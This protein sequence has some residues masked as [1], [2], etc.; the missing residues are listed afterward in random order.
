MAC[1]D[2]AA[3]EAIEAHLVTCADCRFAV[4]ETMASRRPGAE[5]TG[6]T[7]PPAPTWGLDAAPAADAA[8]APEVRGRRRA[9][10]GLQFH[11]TG[12]PAR[13]LAFPTRCLGEEVGATLAAAAAL[14]LIVRIAAGL[15]AMAGRGG[16]PLEGLAALDN[17]RER[18]LEGR[19]IGL[20]GFPYAE[21]PELSSR[22]GG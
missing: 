22:D 13:V 12:T 16:P 20:G 2:A 3:R 14:F 17:R 9:G 19:L 6:D 11:V 1:C 21:A 15:D 8:P 4:V 5:P 10:C 7:A 18:P